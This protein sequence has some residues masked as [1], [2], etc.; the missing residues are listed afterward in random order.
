MIQH[1]LSAAPSVGSPLFAAGLPAR[2]GVGLKPEHIAEILCSKPELGFFEIHAEN[3]MVAGGPYHQHLTQI[4]AQYA[5]SVH[6]VGLSLGGEAAPDPT[7]LLRLKRLLDRYQ[8]A[9]FSEHLAW[10]GHQG[11]FLNDL[12][13]L[14]YTRHTL[15]RVCEH[16][17][18]VQAFLQRPILVENPATYLTFR[19]SSFSEAE[20][21]R[22]VVRRTG[23]GLLLDINNVYVSC[24]NH[25]LDP[26][27]YIDQLPLSAVGEIHLAGFHEEQ[28][29]NGER[30]LIDSHGA[31][32][33]DAVWQ[34][35]AYAV[36]KTG[37]VATLI[38]RDQNL[39]A[40]AVLL[41]EAKQAEQIM[42][43]S[44]EVHCYG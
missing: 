42:L 8:P 10:S 36:Q 43:A 17:A 16:V 33:A 44:R 18:Q 27:A 2:G 41:A 7:H 28:D 23:C 31:A 9:S 26:Y 25:R 4:R 38:E 14:P 40:F 19:D 12:L 15:T 11:Q 29:L 3:Y 24:V 37:P 32:V 1:P 34:L 5:L 13:P 35:Y 30:L 39:P 6:G 20:F 21:I 22:E